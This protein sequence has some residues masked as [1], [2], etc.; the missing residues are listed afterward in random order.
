MAEHHPHAQVLEARRMHIRRA[1]LILF[2]HLVSNGW[3]WTFNPLWVV[4]IMV[5]FIVLS[6]LALVSASPAP[7]FLVHPMV[8]DALR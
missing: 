6:F 1:H 7:S 8:S 3:V 5:S 2:G 4:T